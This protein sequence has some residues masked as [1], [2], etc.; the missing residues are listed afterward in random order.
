MLDTASCK[1]SQSKR[2]RPENTPFTEPRPENISQSECYGM[3]ALGLCLFTLPERII[4][5]KY[6]L[7]IHVR[8]N[9]KWD[10]EDQKLEGFL[11]KLSLH[12][13]WS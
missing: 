10:L 2:N 6:R 11:Y 7:Q 3:E 13:P 5:A 9:E 12:L 8:F 4:V 1:T